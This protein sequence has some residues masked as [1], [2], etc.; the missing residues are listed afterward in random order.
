MRLLK[1]GREQGG[2]LLVTLITCL[3]IGIVLASYMGLVSSR[4]KI[5]IRSQCWNAAIPVAEQ[6][7]EEALAHL[8]ADSNTP[9]ANNWTLGIIAGQNV[10]SKQRTNADGSY[11]LANLYYTGTNNPFIYGTGFVPTPL[12]A[13]SYISRTIKVTCTNPPVFSYGIAV[14][15]ALQMN[16]GS[17]TFS[18]DSYDSSDPLYSTNGQYLPSMATTN[19][20]VGDV[21]GP[22]NLGNHVIAGNL[23]LGPEVS[24]AS[25]GPG[26]VTGQIYTDFN[27]SFPDAQ[28]PS[29]LTNA[30]PAVSTNGQYVF[31]MNGSWS[32]PSTG[33]STPIVVM[34]GVSVQLRVDATSFNPT[35]IHVMATNGIS[36]TLNLYQVSGSM[37]LSGSAVVD[38]GISRNFYYY[39]LPGVTSITCGGSSTFVGAIYAPEANMTLSGGGSGNNFVGALVV[40]N[41][42]LSGHYNIH[43]DSALLRYG[44]KR[45]YVPASWQ[46]M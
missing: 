25:I 41:L 21:Y 46:E 19:G 35:S 1:P 31:T 42:T 14:I 23:S 43:F 17:P 16:G 29:N 34:P 44:P 8:H 24:T 4:Y 27:V 12:D 30:P 3:V 7:V 26:Q 28:L 33:G 2:T 20:N 15:Y 13:G 39:G 45:G 6:G 36:G 11:F 38:S 9:A 32:I 5:T 18:S 37:T 40:K 22:V 10:Y